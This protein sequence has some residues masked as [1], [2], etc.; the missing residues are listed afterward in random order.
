MRNNLISLIYR[1]FSGL[2]RSGITSALLICS[3]ML[4]TWPSMSGESDCER[5]CVQIDNILNTYRELLSILNVMSKCSVISF[6]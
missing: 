4:L 5:A 3:G 1:A 6:V 2:R